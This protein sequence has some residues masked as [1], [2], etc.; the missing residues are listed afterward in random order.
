MGV[1]VDLVEIAR[2]GR[3]LERHPSFAERHFTP[4]ERQRAELLPPGRRL[5]FL[6]GRFAAKEA[7][8]KAL[9]AGISGG[10]ALAEIETEVAPSGAPVLRLRGAALQAAA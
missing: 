7:A 3:V 1:G 10:V 4:G 9:G 2:L 8:L 6:A 5:E